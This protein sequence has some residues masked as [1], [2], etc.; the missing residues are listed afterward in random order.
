MKLKILTLA[1]VLAFSASIPSINADSCPNV[2]FYF[3]GNS[4]SDYK[5]LTLGSTFATLTSPYYDI[6]KKTIFYTTGWM[7][8]YSSFDAQTIL[9]ALLSRKSAYNLVYVDWSNYTQDWFVLSM[10]NQTS[11]VANTVYQIISQMQTQLALTPDKINFVGFNFGAHLFG[12]VGRQFTGTKVGRITGLDPGAIFTF[13]DMIF[14]AYNFVPL[15]SSDATFVDIIHTSNDKFG[16]KN[17]TGTVDFYV[18]G[19]FTQPG[20]S[21][22]K[23]FLDY[24]PYQDRSHGYLLV[25]SHSRVVFLYAES[26]K[27]ADTAARP[28]LSSRCVTGT[29]TYNA[30]NC[31]DTSDNMSMGYFAFNPPALSGYSNIFYVATTNNS[32]QFS[33]T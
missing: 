8:D 7:C 16:C 25:C 5:N 20:C 12:Y 9:G 10:L 31:T 33:L 6:T 21:L 24:K 17:A 28:F 4:L 14:N 13:T 22:I 2:F 3:V 18:N 32:A 19:G 30:N 26:V 15:Q 1:F 11:C 29:T 23:S 27:R